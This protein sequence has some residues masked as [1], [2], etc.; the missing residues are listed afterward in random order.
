M[1]SADDPRG[2]ETDGRPDFSP[3][4]THRG[5]ECRRRRRRHAGAGADRVR[6]EYRGGP[7]AALK[8]SADASKY[9]TVLT[10]FE[11][12]ECM[13]RSPMISASGEPNI[14]LTGSGALGAGGASSWNKGSDRAFLDSLV[15]KGVTDP[16][17]RVVP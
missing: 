5:T 11:G 12:S 9:P 1:T 8:Y 7:G 17:K 6:R 15:A 16:G 14:A 3:A 10:R 2:V 13:S 4:R